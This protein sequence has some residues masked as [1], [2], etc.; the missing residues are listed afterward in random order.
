MALM[1]IEFYEDGGDK[2]TEVKP[3]V[4]G[5][6]IS[7]VEDTSLTASVEHITIP[8]NASY[9]T[10][11]TDTNLY[12]EAGSGNQD[13][14]STRRAVVSSSTAYRTFMVNIGETT[15]SYRSIT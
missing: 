5:R 2:G 14:G 12:V 4:H 8:L 11:Y 7:S 10:I 6:L 1:A 13:C 15:V 9:Y 3:N